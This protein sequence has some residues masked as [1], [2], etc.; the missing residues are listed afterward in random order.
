MFYSVKD[1]HEALK[2]NPLLFQSTFAYSCRTGNKLSKAKVAKALRQVKDAIAKYEPEV[3][4]DGQTVYLQKFTRP[5]SVV[6][7]LQVFDVPEGDFS[8]GVEVEYGFRSPVAARKVIQFVKNWKHIAI[9]REGGYNGVETTFPPVLYSKLTKR[10]QVFRYLTYLHANQ[11][12]LAE[13]WGRVGTHVNVGAS[14]SPNSNSL[15]R[16]NAILINLTQAQ[17]VRYF[18]RDPYGYGYVRSNGLYNR[19]RRQWIEWKLFNSVT[20]PA[21]AKRYIDIAV[22]LTKLTHTHSH[23]QLTMQVVLDTLEAAYNGRVA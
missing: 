11:R 12:L 20:D 2:K 10:A 5:W 3:R 18:G 6:E 8:V 9:D 4:I 19:Q 17:K 13:H 23:E 16:L 22:A 21:V 15:N 7:N 1:T 14:C